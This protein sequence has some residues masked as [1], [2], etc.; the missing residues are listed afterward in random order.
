MKR[1]FWGNR[2]VSIRAHLVGIL[3]RADAAGR[4]SQGV[5]VLGHGVPEVLLV[6]LQ[7][8]RRATDVGRAGATVEP[9]LDDVQG[10]RLEARRQ[11][12][13]EVEVG[14]VVRREA[15]DV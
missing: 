10:V 13:E 6:R 4:R 9:V 7:K 2:S 5:S 8:P 3:A 14:G 12:A 11:A 15:I 1:R